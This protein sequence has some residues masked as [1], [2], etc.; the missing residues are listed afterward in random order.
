[1]CCKCKYSWSLL[2]SVS[3]IS[4]S[5]FSHSIFE[6]LP[7]NEFLVWSVLSG[8]FLLLL[9]HSKQHLF[10]LDNIYLSNF[11]GGIEV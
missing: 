5:I 10:D 2:V 1:M 6:S 7:V 9:F 11:F 8:L 4:F 3:L